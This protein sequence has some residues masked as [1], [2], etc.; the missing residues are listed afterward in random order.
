MN[1]LLI[2]LALL[3]ASQSVSAQQ[4]ECFTE[5]KP[6]Y[7]TALGTS[8]SGTTAIRNFT[9]VSPAHKDLAACTEALD[10]LKADRGVSSTD[11]IVTQTIRITG[12]CLAVEI[13][14]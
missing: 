5:E 11:G 12:K 4:A 3:V 1:K 14:P 8:K 2:V 6:H 13:C 7:F 9:Y 10:M